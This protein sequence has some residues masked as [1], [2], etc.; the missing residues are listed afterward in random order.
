MLSSAKDKLTFISSPLDFCSSFNS[1]T[2][3]KS[4]SHLLLVQKAGT[5]VMSDV[6]HRNHFNPHVLVA[7]CF[8]APSATFTE[9][10]TIL[11]P[12]CALW[13]SGRTI[14]SLQ[15]CL[16]FL[17]SVVCGVGEKRTEYLLL[18]PLFS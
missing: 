4:V 6:K 8:S 9:V 13:S 1:C 16:H 10:F 2:P 11:R 17:Y 3:Q 14:I 5:K 12:Y 18:G 15:P 7:F